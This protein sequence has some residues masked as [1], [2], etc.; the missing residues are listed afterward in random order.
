VLAKFPTAGEKEVASRVARLH[1]GGRNWDTPNAAILTS[2]DANDYVK[3][4]LGNR[5]G[6]GEW[7]SLRCTQDFGNTVQT[8]V[9]GTNGKGI[10]GLQF[11]ALTL[12]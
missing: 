7:R 8:V 6:E 5:R 1:N 11:T 12:N 3:R 4:F 10:G 9:P 2:V